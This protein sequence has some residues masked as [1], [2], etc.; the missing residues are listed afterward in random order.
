MTLVFETADYVAH[1]DRMGHWE[2]R[3]KD[4]GAAVYLQGDDAR[5]FSWS[6]KRLPARMINAAIDEYQEVMT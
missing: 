1:R 3:R 4:S 5:Q 2:L 6:V